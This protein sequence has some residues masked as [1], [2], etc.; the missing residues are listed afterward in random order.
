MGIRISR[1]HANHKNKSS[2]TSHSDGFW[3]A[4]Y[5]NSDNFLGRGEPRVRPKSHG[6]TGMDTDMFPAHANLFAWF[7]ELFSP[8]GCE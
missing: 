8:C 3:T 4:N 2:Q 7:T 5:P 6:F 1:I